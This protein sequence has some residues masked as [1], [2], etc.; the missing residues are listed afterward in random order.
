MQC[1]E[2]NHP[3]AKVTDSRE[4]AEGIRRRREC[5]SCGHR[6]TTL[7]RYQPASLQV[8]KRDGRLEGFDQ[9]NVRAGVLRACARRPVT[10]EAIDRLVESVEQAVRR[11]NRTEVP[12]SL[13]GALVMEPLRALDPVAYLRFASVYRNF[14]DVESFLKEAQG[15]LDQAP[16][17]GSR[18]AARGIVSAVLPEAQ[19]PLPLNGNGRK[20]SRRWRA[21]RSTTPS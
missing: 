18:P 12:S 21:R 5:Q 20:H 2:C 15:L 8:I 7:E 13:I 16:A 19:L 17:E 14:Q 11:L 10:M 1:P 4:S 3:D 6:F 9:N